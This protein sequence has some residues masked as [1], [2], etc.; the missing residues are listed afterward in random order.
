MKTKEEIAL[1]KKEWCLKNKERLKLKAH[2][3]YL[4]RRILKRAV[5][6]EEE[7][8][9]LRKESYSKYNQKPIAKYSFHKNNSTKRGISWEFTF[10]SWWKMW[11]ES[12]KWEQRGK[13][14]DSFCMCR[15]GDVGPYSP[16][17]CYI[18]LFS[19]NAQ[20]PRLR[21]KQKT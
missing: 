18:G 12:G 1:Y 2:E 20:E 10:E 13:S 5:I 3:N 17:N 16:E 4:K 6:S 15:K 11:E 19:I 21:E 7:R 8:K 14:K 9:I